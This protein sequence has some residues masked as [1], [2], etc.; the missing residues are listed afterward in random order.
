[1]IARGRGDHSGSIM[2][3][4]TWGRK[5]IETHRAGT[6][7]GMASALTAGLNP[8]QAR[9]LDRIQRSI[10]ASNAQM[11]RILNRF[12][13]ETI[14]LDQIKALIKAAAGPSRKLLARRARQLGELAQSHQQLVARR[15]SMTQQLES[16]QGVEI[17][18]WDRAFPGVTVRVGEH[19]QELIDEVSAPRF[20]IKEDELA[21]R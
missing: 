6:M 1:M 19:R 3:G 13:L 12:A 21:Y 8:L 18:V 9:E 11:E 17:K 5:G 15:R 10:A 2:G 4:E 7:H 20:H 16:G 14:D